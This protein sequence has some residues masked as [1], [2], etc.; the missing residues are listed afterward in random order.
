MISIAVFRRRS[1]RRPAVFFF[2]LRRINFNPSLRTNP[3]HSLI[4]RSNYQGT[5][6]LSNG[7][8]NTLVC[9]QKQR[10]FHG[11]IGP[12]TRQKGYLL[13][14]IAC[15]AFR[16]CRIVPCGVRVFQYFTEH[17]AA[18]YSSENLKF[19]NAAGQFAELSGV[20]QD[21]RS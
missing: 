2:Q 4:L 11:N 18:E 15:F 7:C 21:V 19:Y 14:A 5:T 9:Q 6:L 10:T 1:L 12:S 3:R 17:V 13:A 20:P 16:F 8:T